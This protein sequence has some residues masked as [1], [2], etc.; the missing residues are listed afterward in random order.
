[1]DAAEQRTIMDKGRILI[2]D[3]EEIVR[4]SC[5][6]ILLPEGYTVK[7]ANNAKNGLALLETN[8]LDLVLTDLKM[9]DM[10]GLEVLRNIKEKWPETEVIIMTGYGTVKTAVRAMKIGVFDYIEKPFTPGDLIPLAAKALSGP[11][12][13]RGMLRLEQGSGKRVNQPATRGWPRRIRDRGQS[14]AIGG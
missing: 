13:V 1:M 4:A 9:P 8:S 11:W 7:T 6:R 3:D 14:L 10:D 5:S 2:I 12:I